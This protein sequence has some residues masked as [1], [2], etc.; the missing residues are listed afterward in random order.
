MIA[1]NIKHHPTTSNNSTN[2]DGR[3]AHMTHM[4][5]AAQKNC[6]FKEPAVTK[7]P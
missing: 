3:M 4:L 5:I 6:L 7:R 2:V 1:N